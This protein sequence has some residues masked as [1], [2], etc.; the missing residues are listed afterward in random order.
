MSSAR[1]AE[2]RAR[3][4]RKARAVSC[5]M[6]GP[7]ERSATIGAPKPSRQGRARSDRLPS[8]IG[9]RHQFPRE[10]GTGSHTPKKARHFTAFPE[11]L[12][13]RRVEEELHVALGPAKRRF[14][15]PQAL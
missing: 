13:P 6:G 7:L 15:R 3:A 8:E 9:D 14:H 12:A 2:G 11:S 4:V 10:L 5:F 1:A